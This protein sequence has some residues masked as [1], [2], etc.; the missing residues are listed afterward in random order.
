[1]ADERVPGRKAI[2][3]FLPGRRDH[4]YQAVSLP[5]RMSTPKVKKA[6]TID[7]LLTS[8][9]PNRHDLT[10]PQ[11][12]HLAVTPSSSKDRVESHGPFG[13]SL[14]PLYSGGIAT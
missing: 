6:P 1:M 2:L 9:L 4:S 3:P 12:I 7:Q 11:L 10:A 14:E 8:Y 13:I 5:D